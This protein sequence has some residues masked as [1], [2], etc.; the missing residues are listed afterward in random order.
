MDMV[1][2]QCFAVIEPPCI[3]GQK[4]ELVTNSADGVPWLGSSQSLLGHPTIREMP[5]SVLVL[6]TDTFYHVHFTLYPAT[7][8]RDEACDV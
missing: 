2:Q 3:H 1:K 4:A 8:T 6:S 5:R 7:S